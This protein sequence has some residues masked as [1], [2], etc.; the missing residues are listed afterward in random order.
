[1]TDLD[2]LNGS[3]LDVD[4]LPNGTWVALCHRDREYAVATAERR[5]D[6]PGRL[7]PSLIRWLPDGNILVVDGSGRSPDPNAFVFGRDGASR[8]AFD[9]GESI[10]EV[11]A[12]DDG[13]FVTYDDRDWYQQSDALSACGP[14]LF[15][16]AGALQYAYGRDQPGAYDWRDDSEGSRCACRIGATAVC[17]C[18]ALDSLLVCLE[19][20]ARAQT[21]HRLPGVLAGPA[22]VTNDG[23]EFFFHDPERVRGGVLRW[24]PGTTPLKIGDYPRSR[25]QESQRRPLRGR[26]DGTFLEPRERGFAVVRLP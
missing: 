4:V 1:M 14:C 9:I 17:F 25:P 2:I 7:W 3:V 22:A 23:C 10:S 15:S 21:V 18:T 13:L 20:R 6:L 26:S 16:A 5:F 11:L 8:A 19:L 12:L 24:R